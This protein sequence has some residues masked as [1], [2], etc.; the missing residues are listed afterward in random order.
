MMSDGGTMRVQ[1]GVGSR[2]VWHCV[3]SWC[4]FANELAAIWRWCRVYLEADSGA[5][6]LIG[7]LRVVSLTLLF[8]TDYS[9]YTRVRRRYISNCWGIARRTFTVA[10]RVPV[11]SEHLSSE[12]TTHL[13]PAASHWWRM[14]RRA[15]PRAGH[16]TSGSGPCQGEKMHKQMFMQVE[17]CSA[18]GRIA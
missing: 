15:L 2:F 9:L 10:Q 11:A 14:G 16:T 4:R 1:H 7:L 3:D 6:L 8:D 17:C 18:V 13:Q 12:C 5:K